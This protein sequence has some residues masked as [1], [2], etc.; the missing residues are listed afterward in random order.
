MEYRKI[1]KTSFFQSYTSH[2]DL[3][4]QDDGLTGV[5]CTLVAALRRM[6][7]AH[8][9]LDIGAGNG[10][11][12]ILFATHG[13]HYTGID[14]HEHPDWLAMSERFPGQIRFIHSEFLDWEPDVTFS[15]VLDN[16][17]FHHQHPDDD[18][19][20]LGKIYHLLHDDGLLVLGLYPVTEGDD[21]TCTVMPSGKLKR[22]FSAQS[23]AKLLQEHGFLCLSLQPV[24]SAR[25]DRYY[26]AALSRKILHDESGRDNR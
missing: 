11:H 14:F 15:A 3:W 6:D 4:S 8:T 10:R 21:Y 17:C 7:G 13:W 22:S 24:Y 1:L 18:Q 19:R 16:G 23:I 9:I 5:A 2:T 12:S 20:Y 25:R 26:L